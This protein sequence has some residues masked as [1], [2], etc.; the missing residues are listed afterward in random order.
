[1][2][3]KKHPDTLKVVR[4]GAIHAREVGHIDPPQVEGGVR[5]RV[6]RAGAIRAWGYAT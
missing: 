6:V 2:L 5:A 3:D 1:M 4:A